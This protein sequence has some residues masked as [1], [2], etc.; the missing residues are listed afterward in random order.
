MSHGR[1]TVS[2]STRAPGNTGTHVGSL[3]SADGV[4]LAR[5]TFTDESATGWQSVRFATPVPI[6]PHTTYVA[7]YHAPAGGYAFDGGYFAADATS[8]DGSLH[9]P[10]GA[11]GVFTYSAAPIFPTSTFNST[12]Y[13]VDVMYA[14]DISATEAAAFTI[15]TSSTGSSATDG[16][17]LSD[18]L[19]AGLAWAQ[20][21][22]AN[23]SISGGV[24]TCHYGTLA[25][26][27]TRSCTSPA[28]TT[29]ATSRTSWTDH[30]TDAVAGRAPRAAACWCGT[31]DPD[32]HSHIY[33]CSN[34]RFNDQRGP[35]GPQGPRP[36]L[37]P[38]PA[39]RSDR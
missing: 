16:V 2:G 8:R 10:A 26:G 23:C 34:G 11:N 14:T 28:P 18:V 15:A 38:T 1:S 36:R 22:P 5:A 30:M 7:S 39:I 25:P 6:T 37:V 4:L 12:N 21:D 31:A 17:T 13:W 33:Q 35:R 19:P 32:D 20:D 3:W 29:T 27:S 24:L 9:A